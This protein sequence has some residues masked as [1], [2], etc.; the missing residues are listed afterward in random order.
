MAHSAASFFCS[1]GGKG[2]RPFHLLQSHQ[3][4]PSDISL[5]LVNLYGLTLL[6]LS[7]WTDAISTHPPPS[8]HLPSFSSSLSAFP[9]TSTILQKDRVCLSL[10]N[11]LQALKARSSYDAAL[12][13][14]F[15]SESLRNSLFDFHAKPVDFNHLLPPILP[16]TPTPRSHSHA[17]QCS[18]SP[19]LCSYLLELTSQPLLLSP[20]RIFWTISVIVFFRPQHPLDCVLRAPSAPLDSLLMVGARLFY[21]LSIVHCSDCLAIF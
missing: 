13:S 16:Q 12:L 7:H 14:N 9:Q 21:M 17:L 2:S 4:Y 19:I 18:R 15:I 10:C 1:P 3:N 11:L 20:L 5:S 6:H 8:H